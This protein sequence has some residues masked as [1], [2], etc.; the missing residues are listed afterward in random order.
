MSIN[1][2]LC[3]TCGI[4]D[5]FIWEVLPNCP[6]VEHFAT[7]QHFWW[8]CI[9]DLIWLRCIA[10]AAS[11]LWCRATLLLYVMWLGLKLQINT[12]QKRFWVLVCLCLRQ[13]W[14]YCR[15]KQ[16]SKT[17]TQAVKLWSHFIILEYNLQFNKFP[18]LFSLDETCCWDEKTLTRQYQLVRL[19]SPRP[20]PDTVW[21]C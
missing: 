2:D 6:S 14:S 9:A 19:S 7:Y 3:L 16:L 5:L 1:M 13:L 17:E 8:A 21:L 18:F 15:L 4:L 10:C 11:G 12:F 20:L